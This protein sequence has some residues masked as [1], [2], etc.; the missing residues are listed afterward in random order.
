[1]SEKQVDVVSAVLSFSTTA[2]DE[3]FAP[4]VIRIAHAG[5]N[6][7]KS[8]ISKAVFEQNAKTA[9]GCP[10][11]CAYDISEDSSAATTRPLFA[12]MT[13]PGSSI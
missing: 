8:V 10:I 1:V 9:Y 7:N 4:C 3:R 13:A 5:L 12:Q 2:N 11:V 6:R